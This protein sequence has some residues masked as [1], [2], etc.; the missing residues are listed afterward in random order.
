MLLTNLVFTPPLL[1][2]VSCVYVQS[3]LYK[4]IPIETDYFLLIRFPDNSVFSQ[5]KPPSWQPSF[6]GSILFCVI[7]IQ[8][9]LLFVS[10]VKTHRRYIRNV[11]SRGG[12]SLWS[13]SW[14]NLS[15]K[16][17]F[18]QSFYS[19]FSNMSNCNCKGKLTYWYALRI[20]TSRGYYYYCHFLLQN[21]SI[22]RARSGLERCWITRKS[23]LSGYI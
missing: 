4:I 16:S 20:I 14:E 19:F 5:T 17:K 1:P 6:W 21:P 23:V 3:F 8:S 13:F 11:D 9:L 15:E 18:I 7:N 10:V 12:R 22:N 2:H